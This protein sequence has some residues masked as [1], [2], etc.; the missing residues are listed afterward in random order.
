MPEAG[1]EDPMTWIKTV[2]LS[3]ADEKLL[4]ALQSQA[5]MYPA[6]YQTPV[7]SVAGAQA[8]GDGPSVIMSHSLIPDALR[9]AF[10]TFGALM[11]P[12]LP[13]KRRDH[14]LIAATVSSINDCFY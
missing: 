12:D 9:H 1:V 13:L 8:E 7:E 3:E 4:D 2:P 6:E 10:S 11:S 14:E 5:P